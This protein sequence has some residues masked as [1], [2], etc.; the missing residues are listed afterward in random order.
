MIK[1]YI[2]FIN[3]NIDRTIEILE[4]RFLEFCDEYNLDI[5]I[6]KG[7][8]A[9]GGFI[10][11]KMLPSVLELANKEGLDIDIDDCYRVSFRPKSRTGSIIREIGEDWTDKELKEK[12][13]NIDLKKSIDKVSK[14]TNLVSS[15]DPYIT[16]VSWGIT[17][18]LI[19]P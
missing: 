3:E 11:P 16:S 19:K 6:D 18:Y 15:S 7:Y 5:D 17:I 13:I 12:E 9:N 2:E 10:T 14:L 4:D 1:S 8:I